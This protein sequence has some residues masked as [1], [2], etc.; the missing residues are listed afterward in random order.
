MKL[1]SK[2]PTEKFK[3]FRKTTYSNENRKGWITV[4]V[5]STTITVTVAETA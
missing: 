5:Q 3:K 1:I 2:T 4:E